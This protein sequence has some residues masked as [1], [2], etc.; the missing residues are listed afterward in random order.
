MP[1]EEEYDNGD[2][3]KQ[4]SVTMDTLKTVGMIVG[5]AIVGAMIVMYIYTIVPKKV[6]ATTH[7]HW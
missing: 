6:T 3:S 1:E 2:K 7:W 4:K 5:A